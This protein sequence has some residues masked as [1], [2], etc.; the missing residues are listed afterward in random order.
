MDEQKI[1]ALL[2]H[3]EWSRELLDH[4]E[5]HPTEDGSTLMNRC[6]NY[7]YRVNNMDALLEPYIGKLEEFIEFISKQWGWIITY[8]K[9]KQII[10]ADEN[11]GYCVCPIASISES[12]KNAGFLCHCS[13]GFAKLMFGKIIGKEVNAEVIKSVLRG[14]KTCMYKILY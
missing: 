6:A 3:S 14:D 11:K 10:I 8:D 7:H 9:Q 2:F 5:K 1:N 13:E 4:M 12:Y